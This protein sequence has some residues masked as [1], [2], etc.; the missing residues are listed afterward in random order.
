MNCKHL[1]IGTRIE[2]L[3]KY[4]EPICLTYTY[5]LLCRKTLS[6]GVGFIDK[7]KNNRI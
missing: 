7:K 5:C 4:G 1:K 2:L 6:G 3:K